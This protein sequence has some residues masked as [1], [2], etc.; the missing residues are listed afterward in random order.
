MQTVN[1]ADNPRATYYL[2]SASGI[3]AVALNVL[4]VFLLAELP[5]AYKVN[6]LREW[7]KESMTHP[8]E[9]GWSAWAFTL[10]VLLLAPFAY[11]LHHRLRHKGS[12]LTAIAA[13]FVSLAGVMNAA[14]TLTPF[15]LVRHVLPNYEGQLPSCEPIAFALL[16]FTLS[17]DALFNVLFGAGMILFGFALFKQPHSKFWLGAFGIVAGLSALPIVLQAHSVFFANFL[18]VAGPLW[19]FWVSAVSIWL[20]IEAERSHQ[21]AGV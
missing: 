3:A 21:S 7:L 10:G 16:G 14:G 18:I 20:M 8:S 12:G 17:M 1:S 19:L 6:A 13:I 15:V 9:T 11:G 4:A 5:H 2:A